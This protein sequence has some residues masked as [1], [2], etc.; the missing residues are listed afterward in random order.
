MIIFFFIITEEYLTNT[1]SKG[2]SRS[3]TPEGSDDNVA[4]AEKLLI[5]PERISDKNE[6][7]T[8]DF[9]DM[10][11]FKRYLSQLHTNTYLF[12]TQSIK[13]IILIVSLIIF[14]YTFFFISLNIIKIYF[15]SQFVE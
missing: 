6:L 15:F 2:S 4:N 5:V 10:T 8:D 3:G 12:V 1:G 13:I 9:I 7:S 14:L 11:Y